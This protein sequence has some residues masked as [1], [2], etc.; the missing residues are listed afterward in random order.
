[1]TRET[2]LITGASTGIGRELAHC[3]AKDGADLI[4]V[5]R[6][7]DR[8]DSVADVLRGELGNRIHVV[9]CDLSDPL[10]PS[11]LASFVSQNALT[12]D[13]LVNNAGFGA[14]G[15]FLKLPL[16]RQL[17]MIQ[18]NVTSLV[19]LTGLFLPGMLERR[20]GGILNISSTA[21][22]QAGPNM[23]IYYATKAFVQSFSEAIYEETRGT[24]VVIGTFAPG[25]TATDFGA[26]SGMDRSHFFE[27]QSMDAA[28]VAK[29][30]YRSFRLGKHFVIPGLKNRISTTAVKFMPR[31]WS[32]R[33]VQ[34]IKF[35]ALRPTP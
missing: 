20:R 14:V 31:S 21:A 28:Q 25:P 3:F 33:I 16:D 17:D 7:K 23:A 24:G 13:V 26:A 22:F 30:G 2:V 34:R 5:A 10:A 18:V 6:H 19:H 8:L 35:D 12:I 27:S 4:L 11:Q 15:E 1:M 9:P 32:R 29:M